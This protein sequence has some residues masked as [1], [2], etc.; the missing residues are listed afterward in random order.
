MLFYH[1][2][3]L[4]AFVDLDIAVGHPSLKTLNRIPSE[5]S[6]HANTL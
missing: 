1:T 3:Y 6:P 2:F 5:R 4:A